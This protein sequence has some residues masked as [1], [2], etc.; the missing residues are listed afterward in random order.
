MPKASSAERSRLDE[1]Q[2]FSTSLYLRGLHCSGLANV[3]KT[4]TEP[5]PTLTGTCASAAGHGWTH[6]AALSCGKRAAQSQHRNILLTTQALVFTHP[7][8]GHKASIQNYTNLRPRGQCCDTGEPM[9]P[10]L[11][12]SNDLN[13]RSLTLVAWGPGY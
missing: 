9:L 2:R 13:Q 10:S 1:Q 4:V 6:A 5:L 8:P 11:L 7:Q 3:L 12:F